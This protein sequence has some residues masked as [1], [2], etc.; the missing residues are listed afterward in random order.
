MRFPL[1]FPLFVAVLTSLALGAVPAPGEPRRPGG[2]RIR[3]AGAIGGL[4]TML[5][6]TLELDFQLDAIDYTRPNFVHA[7]LDVET[8]NALQEKRGE[9]LFGMMLRSIVSE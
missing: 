6:N 4:Q 1:L 3:G 8:F 7:D 2:A 9:S 5:K